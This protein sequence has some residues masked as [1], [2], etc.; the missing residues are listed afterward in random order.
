MKTTRRNRNFGFIIKIFIV[1]VTIVAVVFGVYFGLDRVIVPKYFKSYGIN[2]MHDLVS[3]VRTLY[4]SPDEDDIISNGYTTADL[5]SAT[6][7][8]KEANFPMT[9]DGKIDYTVVTEGFD[10][11]Q[12]LSGDYVFSDR[13][14]AAVIDQMLESESGVLANELPH[15]KYIDTI[16]IN[17]LEMVIE[18]TILSGDDEPLIYD[19]E[20]A[21]ISFTSKIDTS[22]VRTQMAKA[23]DTPLFLLNMIV[24]EKL[25]I[26][27]NYDMQK[28]ENGEWNVDNGHMSVNGRTAKDSK[29]LLNLLIDFIFPPEDEMTIDKFCKEFGNIIILGVDVF[30]DVK[31]TMDIDDRDSVGMILSI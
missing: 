15:I 27:V 29:I 30:G 25:Y 5:L 22:A 31:F 24:P 9:D 17:V 18:P 11:G 14:I 4:N 20:S 28:N 13:E 12:L 23:M 1:L 21:K 2:N 10:R 7:K 6:K 3:M 16:N 8:F 19:S 26:T